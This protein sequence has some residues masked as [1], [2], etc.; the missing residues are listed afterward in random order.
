MLGPASDAALGEAQLEARVRPLVHAATREIETS[1]AGASGTLSRRQEDTGW[2]SYP[3]G[4]RVTSGD[5]VQEIS[6]PLEDLG[7]GLG[8]AIG[9]SLVL[10]KEGLVVQRLPEEGEIVVELKRVDETAPAST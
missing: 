5:L 1:G 8:D 2:T 6:G 3:A 4:V 10:F 9:L 7:I